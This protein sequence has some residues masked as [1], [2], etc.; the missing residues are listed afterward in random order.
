M[1]EIFEKINN[2]LAEWDPIGVGVKIASDEYRG[3]IP[4]ILHFLQNRQELI[5]YLETMLVDDIGL[6]YD[7][8]NREHFED[9]QKVCDNL[10]QVYHDSKE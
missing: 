6:S 8:H 5:N 4:K 10:M 3:Y 2:I 9:L 7:P 1:N